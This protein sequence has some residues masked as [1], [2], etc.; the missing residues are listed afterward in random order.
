MLPVPERIC[1]FAKTSV[2]VAW[3]SIRTLP[4][5]FAETAAF[6]IPPVPSFKV[7]VPLSVSR[8][9]LPLP[10]VTRSDSVATVVAPVPVVASSATRFTAKLATV[11]TA[12][13]VDSNRLIDEP[14]PPVVVCAATV[15]TSVSIALSTPAP[16]TPIEVCATSRVVAAQMFTAVAVRALLSRIEPPVAVTATLPQVAWLVSVPPVRSVFLRASKIPS[17]ASIAAK[18]MM[19]AE[20][21]WIVSVESWSIVPVTASTSIVPGFA[22]TITL[23]VP[24][25]VTLRPPRIVMLPVPERICALARTS[26]AVFCASIRM[27][28]EPFAFTAV[29]SAGAVPSF[30]VILPLIVSRTMLPL[31]AVTRSDSVATVL[32]V[33]VV[34][35]SSLTRLAEKV[36]T[37]STATTVD[38]RMLMEEPTP[39][40]V[41]FAASVATSVSIALSTPAPTTPI[42]VIA[43][44]RV[45]AA[46][47]FTADTPTALLSKIEPPVAVTPTLPQVA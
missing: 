21:V 27:L 26:V 42:E 13:A 3:D 22:P 7:M 32:P 23:P 43:C 24:A 39:P 6:A 47:M 30:S 1:A 19:F 31:P 29:E 34:V 36:V 10:A 37:V 12:T 4:D 38:S 17:F 41:V 8:T 44:S 46:Q 9:M 28:P 40:V 2:V 15:A 18:R 45:V 25:K 11:S 33:V 5:P 35:A 16:T 20:S 14:A